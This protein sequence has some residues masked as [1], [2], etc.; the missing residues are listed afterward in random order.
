[1]NFV[2]AMKS[3]LRKLIRIVTIGIVV[4]TWISPLNLAFAQEGQPEGPIYI[5]Q[6]GDT[7]WDIARRFGIPVDEFEGYNGISNPGQITVGMQLVIPGMPGVEG[8]LVTKEIPYGESLRS[9]S[10]RYQVPM[11]ALARLN[12]ITTPSELFTGSFLII[13]EVN[14]ESPAME[15]VSLAP[16][17]SML[18][19]AASH[20]VNPWSIVTTNGIMGSWDVLPG[21]VLRLHKAGALEGPGGLPGHIQAIEVS[22]LPMV[23][24][25]TSVIQLVTQS[26]LSAGG[27]LG[28]HSLNFF[29]LDDSSY[30]ALQGVHAMLEPGFYPLTVN[31][32]LD[33]GT[34]FAFSQQVYVQDGGYA[35]ETLVVNPE[36]IDPENTEPED[37]LWNA[38][39]VAANPDRIW[40]GIFQS[41]VSPLFKDCYPSYYGSRRSYNGSP[42]SY[43]H[44][45]LDFC[46]GVGAEIFAPAAGVVVYTGTLTVRGNATMI[47]HGWGV[48]SGYMHQSEILVN[49]GDHVDAG[50]LIGL[51]GGTGRVTGSHLHL[52]IWV[53]GV[54]VDPMDWLERVYPV[55]ETG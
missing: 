51:V 46:G 40:E 3:V 24:G 14:E 31:G 55:M 25:K 7:L 28:N 8:V 45:G 41:P 23:Q 16:G 50:D 30:V 6:D 44:T 18:E 54:Q 20:R 35:Y 1:M 13:P 42:F 39:P 47:D 21:D 27:S 10:R 53:G 38:L 49:V 48:Y 12:R 43:F 26:E 17:Y 32:T 37:E 9:L 11:D 4:I 29:H 22:P 19:L 33:D 5:V 34:P 52:E 2:L 36:T 15:R